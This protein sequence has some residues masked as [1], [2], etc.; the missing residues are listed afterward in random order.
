MESEIWMDI[1]GFECKYQAS[2][3]GEIRSLKW[4]R[5][6][7][8]R[9]LK[10]YKCGKGYKNGKQKSFRVSRLVWSAFNGPIPDGM[11]INHIDEDTFNDNLENLNIMTP[12]ENNNWGTRI[13]RASIAASKSLTNRRDLS[14][15]VYQY[16]MNMNYIGSW[17]ST[18]EIERV[19]KIP[20]CCIS[21][22]CRG[23]LKQSHGYI[24]AYVK[25]EA[26]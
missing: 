3:T 23:V 25:K 8:T 18:M 5:G 26:S 4:H 24:W 19:L 15:V 6:E 11:Q 12:K 21:A 10:K 22:C 2:N 13:E 9:T 17:E 1:P 7:E 14:K 16:D 20:N